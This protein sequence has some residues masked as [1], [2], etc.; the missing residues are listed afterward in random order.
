MIRKCK[1]EGTATAYANCSLSV[2]MSIFVFLEKNIL[3]KWINKNRSK[4]VHDTWNC[5]SLAIDQSGHKRCR[6][7][8]DLE[9]A[10]V[11]PC[12]NW[13][14]KKKL[15]CVGCSCFVNFKFSKLWIPVFDSESKTL[16]K[17]ILRFFQKNRPLH[18]VSVLLIKNKIFNV[19]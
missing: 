4:L 19:I 10:N 16:S 14:M 12:P 13:L 1:I 11:P 3:E 5:F 8:L 18:F 6:H 2:K 9:R 7:R 17:C 15:K